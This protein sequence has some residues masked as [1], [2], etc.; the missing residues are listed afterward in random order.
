[1]KKQTPFLQLAILSLL[2]CGFT[3]RPPA[4]KAEDLSMAMRYT[5]TV[6]SD[7]SGSIEADVSM[8]KDLVDLIEGQGGTQISCSLLSETTTLDLKDKSQGGNL[9]CVGTIDFSNL[10][11]LIDLTEHELNASV[12]RIEIKDKHFNYDVRT[13][14]GFSSTEST[15]KTEALWI[16]VLPGT[17]GENNADTVSGRTLTWDLSK[18]TSST[19]LAAECA[20]SSGGF[21][22]MDTTT[23]MIAAMALLSCC[24]I[25]V[26][27]IAVVAFVLMRRK[28]SPSAEIAAPAA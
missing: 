7:G 19:H 9:H 23:M 13:S 1:M 4:P 26:L 28:K 11:E 27:V 3:I 14:G 17:P 15:I 6:K 16:L 21:L 2:L 25:L 8:S 10:D 22:G 24:C 18:T 12:N 20:I 5:T